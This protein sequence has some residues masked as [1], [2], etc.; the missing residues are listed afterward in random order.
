MIAPDKLAG[1]TFTWNGGTSDPSGLPPLVPTQYQNLPVVGG[2]FGTQTGNYETFL[3]EN[4]TSYLTVKAIKY[5][6]RCTKSL[7]SRANLEKFQWWVC[8]RGLT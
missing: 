4:Q 3:A 6:Q 2:W 5:F 1:L 7:T 8:L